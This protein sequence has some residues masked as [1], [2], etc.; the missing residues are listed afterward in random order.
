MAFRFR[1]SVKIAKGVRLNFG[2]KGMGVSFGTRGMRYSIHSSGRRTKSVGIP[3]TG[4]SYV[5][6]STGKKKKK[7]QSA[8]SS[9]SA[10]HL[11]ENQALVEEHEH[12]IQTITSLHKISP[13]PILWEEIQNMPAPFTSGEIGP[14]QQKAIHHYEAYAPNL[15]ERIIP[16]LA[17]RKRERFASAIEQAKQQDEKDYREWQELKSLADAVLSGQP[18]AY[19]KVVAESSEFADL[20]YQFHIHDAHRVEMEFQINGDEIPTEQLTLTKTGKV[21]RR[22]MGATNYHEIKKDY[23]SGYAIWAA[24]HLFA[25]LPVERCLIHVTEYALNTATGHMGN[26]VLLSISFNRDIL[27]KLNFA[28]LDPSDAMGNFQHHIDHL[29][30]KGF[31]PVE[32]MTEW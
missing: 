1:K 30:T 5:E 4:L 11:A 26:Q 22:K 21:S 24:R 12:Y 15:I 16:K 3:G 10:N 25:S 14:L 19:K 27:D 18:E 6:T 2:K 29:K 17:E 28:R 31:R 9:S 8:A 20:P 13:E 7:V 23:V 32:R